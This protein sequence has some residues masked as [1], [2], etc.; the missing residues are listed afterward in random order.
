M[1]E[2][3]ME[4]DEDNTESSTPA[5]FN[6]GVLSTISARVASRR[7]TTMR[8]KSELERYLEDELVPIGTENFKILD[9]WKVAGTHYPTLRKVARDIF[10][11]PVTTI[12]SESA[13][14]TGG[15]VL[16]CNTLNLGV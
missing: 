16:S 2:C 4:E 7:P 11:I 6:S 12:A 15:R 10:A 9:W 13:F 5:L 3:E 8:F 14:S 1:K